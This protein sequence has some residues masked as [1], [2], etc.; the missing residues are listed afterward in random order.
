MVMHKRIAWLILIV[1][2]SASLSLFIATRRGRGEASVQPPQRITMKVLRK[3]DQLHVKPTAKEIQENRP[4]AEERSF[5]NLIPAHVPIKVKIP[6]EKEKAFKD[7]KN[8]RWAHDF[9]LEVTNT[10]DKPIYSLSLLLVTE[11]KAAAGYRIVFP[12][13]YG[14]V[15]LGD[16]R[17]RPDAT[18]IPIKPGETYLFR[19]HPGQMQAWE[20]RN[21][22]EN[23][24]HPKKIQVKLEALSF[25]DGSGYV[26][27][28]GEAIPHE[29]HGQSG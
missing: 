19:I 1:I 8:G 18:D 15:E 25:G 14:R 9:E 2:T 12:L 26:G 7:L 6:K 11:V 16:I 20:I 29:R 5:E 3:Q 28:D 27:N 22:L 23:R 21:H 13:S 24:P 10:G 4:A 17:H